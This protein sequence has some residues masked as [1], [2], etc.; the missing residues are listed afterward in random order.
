MLPAK[1]KK[2][3]LW[4]GFISFGHRH[5][6]STSGRSSGVPDCIFDDRKAHER[7]LADISKP[8]VKRRRAFTGL[9]RISDAGMPKN[10]TGVSSGMKLGIVAFILIDLLLVIF[11]LKS[12]WLAES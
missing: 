12:F 3:S 10:N 9:I 7:V 4:R 5:D 8:N 1:K 2:P 6:S 11:F